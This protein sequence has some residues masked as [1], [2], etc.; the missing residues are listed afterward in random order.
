MPVKASIEPF[1]K[2]FSCA[3]FNVIKSVFSPPEAVMQRKEKLRRQNKLRTYLKR[4]VLDFK[5]DSEH[6]PKTK[7]FKKK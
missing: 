1:L 5:I 6:L 4:K 3:K 2:V 7:H